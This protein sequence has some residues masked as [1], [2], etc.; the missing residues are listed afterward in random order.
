MGAALEYWSGRD[1]EP[2]ERKL[3]ENVRHYDCHIVAVTGGD[4][5]SW[6]YS[7]GLF[8]KFGHPEVVIFGL[9]QT[10]AHSM[11]N[12]LAARIREGERFESGAAAEG[13]LAGDF[14]C[15]FRTMADGW[16]DLLI[17]YATWFYRGDDF[18]VV[19]CLWPDMEGRAPWD[20]DFNPDYAELQPLLYNSDRGEARMVRIA[21][22]IES[23]D[24]P[25][26]CSHEIRDWRF[27]D[28]PHRPV[29]T[30]R[31]VAKRGAPILYVSH[32]ADG[33]GWQFL[34]GAPDPQDLAVAHMHHLIE[35]DP[36]L[37]ELFDLPKGWQ[38]WRASSEAAWERGPTP[39]DD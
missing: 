16:R 22:A 30:Q 1:L 35:L 6:Y 19:Q 31:H 33:T 34:D 24:R 3:V 11:I 13:L 29:I 26:E 25:C 32:E 4:M 12:D 14:Q 37:D 20:S 27:S 17:G 5:P 23:P 2:D 28:D 15:V 21:E 39:E 36:S 10:L 7:V 38:A 9:K 8:E 18:P